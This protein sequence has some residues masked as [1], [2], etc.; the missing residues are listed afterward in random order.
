MSKNVVVKVSDKLDYIVWISFEAVNI[1][2]TI[3]EKWTNKNNFD[4]NYNLLYI[5]NKMITTFLIFQFLNLL[6][7]LFSYSIDL[8]L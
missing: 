5:V 7:I 1:E 3:K 2:K 4:D 6:T 8:K